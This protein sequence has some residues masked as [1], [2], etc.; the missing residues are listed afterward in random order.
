VF[1]VGIGEIAVIVLVCLIVFGPDRLPGMARQIGRFLGRVRLTTQGALDQLKQEADLKD[2]N[3]PDL[4]VGSLRTQARDYVR[5]LLDI[6]GQ[7][8]E[9]AREREEIKASLEA[10]V[11]PNGSSDHA[12]T[13]GASTD[14]ASTDGGSTDG[15]STDGGST[16]SA[17]TEESLSAKGATEREASASKAAPVDPEAT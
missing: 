16:D 14:G 7:M 6:E 17:V 12:S 9:L 11:A 10:E 8:A 3:L 13:D 15:G 4:R 5:E 1:N 2:I